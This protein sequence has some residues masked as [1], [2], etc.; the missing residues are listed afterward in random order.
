MAA[1]DEA[2]PPARCGRRDGLPR[3]TRP[4]ATFASRTTPGSAAGA[5]GSGSARSTCRSASGMF[6]QAVAERGVVMTSD[7][8]DDAAFPH[9]D[10]TDRVV[11]DIGI[12]SMVVAPLV[13][14][15]D[16]LRGAGH[17]LVPRRR[18]QPVGRSRS[19]GRWPTMPPRRWPT[20]GSS[21]TST[22]RAASSP[23]GPTSSGRCARSRPGSAPRRDL[24]AVLQLGVDEAAR[25]LDA[26]RRADRPDR[27]DQRAP[28]LGLRVRGGP[29][30]TTTLVAGRPGRDARPGR[31]RPGRRHR[32][33]VLD[34]RLHQRHAVRARPRRRQLRRRRRASARSWPRR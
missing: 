24:P 29:A 17:L 4:P 22:R 13:A 28:A 32:P 19:S 33:G 16:G 30:R 15:R 18:V 9:A 10:D 11:R 23:S 34:R 7:Y 6:G 2:A 5:A 25:L 26:R 27:P 3:S 12:R 1:V 21:R 20:P 8:L 31:L 14:G